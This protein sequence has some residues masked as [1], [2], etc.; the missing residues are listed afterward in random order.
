MIYHITSTKQWNEAEGLNYYECESLHTE[1]FIHSSTFEQVKGVY[2]RYYN[3]STDLIVLCMDET[4]LLAELKYEQ[5]TNNELY[6]HIFGRIN[7]DAVIETK[8]IDFFIL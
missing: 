2:Q 3:G 5:S 1:G 4:K 7:I 6:P 8:E